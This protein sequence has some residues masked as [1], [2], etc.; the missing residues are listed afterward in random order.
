MKSICLSILF[1]L[2]VAGCSQPRVDASAQ[3]EAGGIFR[4]RWWNYYDRALTAVEGRQFAAAKADLAAALQ[5]RENDQRM[6]RTYGMHFSDY[7]PHRELGVVHYLEGDLASAR[8]EL[9]Q[10]IRQ[11][12]TAKA[13]FYLDA[14]RKALIQKRGGPSAPPQ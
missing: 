2:L 6:A 8:A 7:F 12:P 3:D 11:H 1:C 14:V 9:E 10:S 4:H 5:R 13:R